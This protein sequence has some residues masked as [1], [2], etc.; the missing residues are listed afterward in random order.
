MKWLFFAS[1]LIFSA[2]YSGILPFGQ[3][4]IAYSDYFLEAN[5]PRRCAGLKP[6]H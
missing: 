3:N 2:T 6:P 1:N 5:K 4:D